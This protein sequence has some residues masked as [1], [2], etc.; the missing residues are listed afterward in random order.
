MMGGMPITSTM[1]NMPMMHMEMMRM[2]AA[3]GGMAVIDHIEGRKAVVLFTDGVDT[4]FNEG[5]Y[6]K[7][8]ALAEESDAVI[9]SVYYN[10]YLE[11][12]GITNGAK[13]DHRSADTASP[14]V[15]AQ[16]AREPDESVLGGGICLRIGEA[17][18]AGDG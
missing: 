8:L 13:H 17:N 14:V 7:T 16:H 2:M 6:D 3:A 1:G 15:A 5:G 11:M 10:T 4:S 12:A 18:P 9:Y